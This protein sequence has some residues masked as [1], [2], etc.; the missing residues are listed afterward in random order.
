MKKIFAALLMLIVALSC[1]FGCSS[2]PPTEMNSAK[3]EA[4]QKVVDVAK[5]GVKSLIGKLDKNASYTSKDDVAA[6]LHAYKKLP[7][8][9]ITKREA[10][11]LGW[12]KKGTLDKVAPGKSIGGDRF[13][14]YDKL[15]PDKQGRKWQECDID[16]KKGSRNAKRIV[17]SNDGL[18]YYSAD[19]YKSFTKLY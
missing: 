11:Q 8:N 18:I 15:L 5:S 13:G 17:Y 12:Q 3:R 6:Y 7:P 14:N 16:Y 1:L 19:H 2:E 10:E 9:F 4:S